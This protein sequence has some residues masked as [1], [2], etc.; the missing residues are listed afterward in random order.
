MQ[1]FAIQG[2]GF[3]RT[4]ILVHWVELTYVLSSFEA[5]RNDCRECRNWWIVHRPSYDL[6]WMANSVLMHERK[7]NLTTVDQHK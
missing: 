5:H 6:T 3:Y 1:E 4:R 7:Y 2:Y